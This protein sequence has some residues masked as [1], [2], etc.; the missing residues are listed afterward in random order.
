MGIAAAAWGKLTPA[1]KTKY[2]KLGEADKAR[3]ARETAE[4]T[5]KG[6]YTKADG[7]RSAAAVVK[8][9]TATAHTASPEPVQKKVSEKRKPKS[10]SKKEAPKSEDEHTLFDEPQS[11]ELDLE[12]DEE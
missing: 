3:H 1:Q 11:K 4:W 7:T 5:A 10:A 8:A 6:Y 2:E 12:E 9:S